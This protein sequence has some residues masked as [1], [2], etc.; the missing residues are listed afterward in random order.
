[1]RVTNRL[2]RAAGLMA[3]VV[4]LLVGVALPGAAAGGR[5]VDD[6]DSV[7]EADIEFIAGLAVP[8]TAG[9]NP[10][11]NDRF[12]PED[13]VTRG[14]MAAFLVRYFQYPD[15]GGNPFV[16]DD[17]SEF[18]TDIRR[19]AG[20]GVTKGCNTAGDRY[21]PEDDVTRGQ[22]AAFLVRAFGYTDTGSKDFV[23]D[24][25]SIFQAD[26]EK[27]AAAGVT[28]GC[29]PPANDRFCPD[30]PVTRGQMASFLARAL[31]GEGVTTTSTT[32]TTDP[33]NTT[34][35][36]GPTTTTNGSGITTTTI[37]STGWDITTVDARPGAGRESS[38]QAISSLAVIAYRTDGLNILSYARCVHPSCTDRDLVD[39]DE[40]NGTG[41]TLDMAVISG[42]P[43]VAY[44]D[45][46]NSALKVARCTAADCSSVTTRTVV[47][48]PNVG[49]QP[50]IAVLSGLPI[51][52]YFNETQTT[53]DYIRCTT[54]DCATFEGPVTIAP[55][56]MRDSSVGVVN[57]VPAIAYVD[58][59]DGDL[60]LATCTD[61][62]C[63]SVSSQTV[64][65]AGT[66]GSDLD[67]AVIS[68][69]P[70]IAYRD[71]TNGDLQAARCSSGTCSGAATLTVLDGPGD[72]G[73]YVSLTL[74]ADGHG[75]I[76]Y[77]N[78]TNA[79]LKFADCTNANC[80]SAAIEVVDTEGDTGQFSSIA[81]IGGVPVITYLDASA[82]TYG[83]LRLARKS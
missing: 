30:D 1:M 64:D 45:L 17:D 67:M 51:I 78:A 49:T 26:I 37:S 74:G 58:F 13:N 23:D 76:S 69:L 15:P 39:L 60:L 18:E 44:E 28:V 2:G 3:V 80:S 7:H 10:P 54:V 72:T 46:T 48:D 22:M 4:G 53:I 35:S 66:V 68:N 43:V 34:T 8:I 47:A 42:L 9:C 55:G 11:V 33:G 63:T 12:C 79:D 73:H 21:C 62:N 81:N 50:S 75:W 31:R 82:S 19:L 65:G 36:G 27:L 61:A 52:T 40:T 20:A 29:N 5:F 71:A 70:L 59:G 41:R 16:D 6:D 77:Q 25:D 32:S 14:Q 57:G 24:N 83:E 38:V 56:A